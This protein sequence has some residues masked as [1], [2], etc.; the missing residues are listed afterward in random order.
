MQE[1]LRATV[2]T[3]VVTP[4]TSAAELAEDMK[5]RELKALIG[6]GRGGMRMAAALANDLPV[7]VGCVVSVPEVGTELPV[8]S[9]APDPVLLLG[10]CGAWCRR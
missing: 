3:Y 2:Q 9:L 1:R 5:R 6:L 10:A 8:H 7:L 4:A